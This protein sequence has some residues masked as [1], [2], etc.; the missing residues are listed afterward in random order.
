[1]EEFRAPVLAGRVGVSVAVRRTWRREGSLQPFCDIQSASDGERKTPGENRKLRRPCSE[2]LNPIFRSLPVALNITENGQ[3][4][5]RVRG[6]CKAAPLGKQRIDLGGHIVFGL[7]LKP[8]RVSI[9]VV[10]LCG[11]FAGHHHEGKWI[12][13]HGVSLSCLYDSPILSTQVSVRRGE[14]GLLGFESGCSWVS[15]D[16]HLNLSGPFVTCEMPLSVIETS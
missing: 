13:A 12:E 6:Q 5:L 16:A 4:D 15:A 11:S 14:A 7:K 10:T 9:S 3:I 8:D 1:M 2:L